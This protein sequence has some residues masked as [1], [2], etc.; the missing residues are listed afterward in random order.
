MKVNIGPYQ[1]KRRVSVTI[2]DYDAWNL[3]HTLALI[4][5]PGLLK[6]KESKHS[7]TTVE[8]EDVPEEIRGNINVADDNF[9]KRWD[10][11]LDEMIYAFETISSGSIIGDD[12]N[13]RVKNGLRLFAKYYHGL[14]N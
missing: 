13:E 3:D 5:H 8:N 7:A 2:D 10:Y 12:Y 4:I 1:N 11:V 14:W 9:F 6:L